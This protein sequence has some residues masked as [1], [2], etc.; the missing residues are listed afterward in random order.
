MNP[1]VI[2]GSGLAGYTLARELRK[3]DKNTPLRIITADDGR[4][5]SKPML[6][7][8]L[9]HG[10]TPD[11]IATASAEQMAAQLGATIQTQTRASAIDTLR[12]V[13]TAD[14]E[15]ITYS[16]LVLALGADVIKPPLEG[17][18][19]DTVISVNDLVDYTRFRTA[20]AN[21]KHIAIIGAGLIG[22]EFA[23]DL[24]SAGFEVDVIAPGA[25]PLNRLLPEAA[26]RALQE[27]LAHI[28]VN[29]HLGKSVQ[30]VDHAAAGYRLTLSD[31]STLETDA[32]L[33]CVGLKPRISLA[34]SAGMR[35]DRGIVVDR[36]LAASA[37]DVYALGDCAETE[38]LVLMY[39]MPLMNAAR[40]LAKTLAGQPTPVAYPAMPVAVKTPAHPVVVCPPPRG[41][42]GEWQS[43]TLENGVR[44]LFY[45]AE[46]RLCGF[47]LTG[48]MV[49]EKNSLV[50][51]LSAWL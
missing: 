16:K 40:A 42:N 34:Q 39:V 45:D 28:G 3:L 29:W 14:D 15:E 41:V 51:E 38:G 7:N 2:I 32:V 11:Q 50:K 18:A 30:R 49:G 43:E 17:D 33:S 47:A 13:V 25:T 35:V 12:H 4:F 20:I 23:N 44:A 27:G 36:Q 26:G 1:I 8:A 5:Y 9:S 46:N 6:S 37:P 21:A 48:E 10:R 22:C 31:G 24:H 19:V